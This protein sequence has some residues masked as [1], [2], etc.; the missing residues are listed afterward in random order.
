[1]RTLAWVLVI[2]SIVISLGVISHYVW[3]N[4]SPATYIGISSTCEEQVGTSPDKDFDRFVCRRSL[5]ERHGLTPETWKGA[6]H[7]DQPPTTEKSPQATTTTTQKPPTT[8][9]SDEVRAAEMMLC[10]SE[11]DPT[12]PRAEWLDKYDACGGDVDAILQGKVELK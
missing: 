7:H 9:K 2:T 6:L 1:M 10:M 8:E 12:L 4:V 11:I 3:N 5:Q